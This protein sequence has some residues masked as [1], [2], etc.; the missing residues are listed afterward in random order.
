MGFGECCGVYEG[1]EGDGELIP[2]IVSKS[3]D[4]VPTSEIFKILSQYLAVRMLRRLRPNATNLPG[5]R[6][7]KCLHSE[8]LRY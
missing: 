4:I 3:L 7:S 8:C 6:Q 2:I 1:E 5:L